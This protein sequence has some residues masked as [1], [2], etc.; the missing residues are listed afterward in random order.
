[1]LHGLPENR[2]IFSRTG[3]DTHERPWCFERKLVFCLTLR[4]VAHE[5][6]FGFWILDKWREI[7]ISTIPYLHNKS[8][9][10]FGPISSCNYW[11]AGL[12]GW[13]EDSMGWG[14][15]GLMDQERQGFHPCVTIESLTYLTISSI[16]PVPI[17]WMKRYYARRYDYVLHV[18]K[19]MHWMHT[20]SVEW[21]SR[22]RGPYKRGGQLHEKFAKVGSILASRLSIF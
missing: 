4:C 5:M 17:V 3:L 22:A 13:I 7:L 9:P 10:R 2:Y 15:V 14:E 20:Q 11:L 8:P 16:Y 21:T 12:A 18:Y 1:M 6:E 19:T